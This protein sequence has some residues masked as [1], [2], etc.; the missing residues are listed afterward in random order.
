MSA[1][2]KNVE[3]VYPLSPLQ[4]GLL[5]HTLYAPQ[6]GVYIA[7]MICA[8]H[9]D[10]NVAAFKQVWQ[11]VVDRHTVLRTAF[12]WEGLEEPLQVVGRKVR[13]PLAEED[14]RSL[15]SSEQQRR[16]EEHL[17]Q[18]RSR[19]FKLSKA[20]LMRLALIR[21]AEDVYQF[22]WSHH[23]LLLDG[24]STPILLK[25]LFSLYAA[26]GQSRSPSLEAGRPYQDYISWLHRQD[27]S[28]AEDFWRQHL[29]GFDAPTPLGAEGRQSARMASDEGYDR[30]HIDCR[31]KPRPP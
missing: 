29:K 21:L 27:M 31:K 30:Q 11:Q 16:L 24:W 7:Q 15:P 26:S 6:S 20:P 14:W 19:G 17:Q 4:Q 23:Q 8:L 22:V 1:K 28:R 12:V 5:F 10:L 2:N 13:L 18:D 3:A 9:G 25:E